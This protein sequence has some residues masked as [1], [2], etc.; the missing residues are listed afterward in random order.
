VKDPN[1]A[2]ISRAASEALPPPSALANRYHSKGHVPFQRAIILGMNTTNYNTREAVLTFGAALLGFLTSLFSLIGR[3]K[4]SPILTWLL[5]GFGIAIFLWISVPTIFK[6]VNKLIGSYKKRQF[7]RVQQVM[8]NDLVQRFV[9]FVNTDQ[10]LCMTRIL[11][12]VRSSSPDAVDH[13]LSVN[14]LNRWFCTFNNYLRFPTSDIGCFVARCQEFTV[15]IDQFNQDYVLK[16]QKAFEC[17]P[18]L[19]EA[20]IDQLEEFLGEFTPYLR[21]VE[22]WADR[23][24]KGIILHGGQQFGI[25]LVSK[26]KR[27]KTFRRSSGKNIAD[28]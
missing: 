20:H 24:E 5:I 8:L 10:S 6:G 17:G 14:Y 15:I 11:V 18:L 16:A 4:S 12:S 3:T 9:S 2:Q 21:E 7:V 1:A 28:L 22:Q 27:V 23:L 19:Q 25:S 26:F 13:I